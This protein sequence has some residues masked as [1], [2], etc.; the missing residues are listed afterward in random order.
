MRN[1]YFQRMLAAIVMGLLMALATIAQSNKIKSKSFPPGPCHQNLRVCVANMQAQLNTVRAYVQ[2]LKPGDK[3]S[4]NPQPDPPGDP[5]PWYRQARQAFGMLQEEIE[6]LSKYPPSE[7]VGAVNDA[8]EKL[9]RLGQASDRTSARA[10]L[11]A[12]K[13]CIRRLSN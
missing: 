5:D 8:Q 11:A 10:A 3:V 12:M 1:I 6:D 13:P 9:G 7:K 2:R 4:F